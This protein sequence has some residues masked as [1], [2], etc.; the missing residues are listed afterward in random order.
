MSICDQ[1]SIAW[2]NDPA[3]ADSLAGFFVQHVAP[4]Y[5]SHGELQVGRASDPEHWSPDLTH[6]IV[7]QIRGT[8]DNSVAS[9][10]RV[11]TAS[12][13]SGL[14]A[15]A[16]VSFHRGLHSAY[17][18]LEDL[19]VNGALRHNGIGGA[20]LEWIENEV[21]TAGCQRMFLESGIKNHDAHRFFER[22]GFRPCSLVM[23]KSVGD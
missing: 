14:A 1:L 9:G 15:L 19:V 21:R 17:A 20:V 8:L 23:I 7:D 13:T 18:I 22:H 12:I 3:E 4:A 6:L 5:I 2:C 16:L 10:L 11:A